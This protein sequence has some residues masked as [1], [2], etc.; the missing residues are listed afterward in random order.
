MQNGGAH[1]AHGAPLRHLLAYLP[2]LPRSRFRDRRHPRHLR[3]QYPSFLSPMPSMQTS[4]ISLDLHCFVVGQA[5]LLL[6]T[7]HHL[8]FCHLLFLR[9]PN[10]LSGW[11]ALSPNH[12]PR[13]TTQSS[14][15]SRQPFQTRDRRQRSLHILISQT[16]HH[17]SV[18]FSHLHI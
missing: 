13:Q 7:L 10:S 17:T 5:E 2:I 11:R 18:P 6:I 16:R 15:V 8:G 3:G 9:A 4:C 14:R 12:A 1:H